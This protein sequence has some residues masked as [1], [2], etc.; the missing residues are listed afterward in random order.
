MT[1]QPPWISQTGRRRVVLMGTLATGG[2]CTVLFEERRDDWLMWP[3]GID[4]QAVRLV[5]ADVR[6]AAQQLLG[7]AA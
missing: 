4:K 7:G 5:K 2:E 6:R 3:Y 1:G